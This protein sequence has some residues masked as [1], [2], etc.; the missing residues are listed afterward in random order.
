[1]VN[2]SINKLPEDLVYCILLRFPVKS[3]MRFKCISQVWYHFIQSTTFINLHLNRTTSVE[4]EFILFKYSIKE[5]AEEFKNVLSFLSGHDD[6]ALNPLFPD[7]DVSYMASNCSCTF[8]PLIGPCNG[9]IALTD[10]ITTI[11]INPATRNFRLL[12]PS[13]FGCPYGYHRSVEALGFVFDSIAN[14]YKIVRLSEVF[15]DPLND[16]PGPKESKVDIYDLSIDSWRELDCEQLPLIDR[17]PCAETFYKEAVH[18]FGTIYLT[19]VILC[20]DVSTEVFRNMKMPRTFILDNAQFPGLVIL[21]ESL[22]LI[23]YPNPSA[24]DHMQKVTHIWV[25]KEYGV[26]ESWILKDIIRLPPIEYPLDIWKNNLLLFQS[27][28]GLLISYNL[29]SDE[30][31]ELKLN[32]V[33]GSMSVKV[34]KESLT[35]IPRGLKL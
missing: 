4:D 11:L 7:V 2:G 24:I 31:K 6:D 22:T 15:W 1:M 20:F 34:Y 8:F 25:M 26:S 16:Y 14:D 19:M 21:S 23:C 17:V 5:D 13:P 3:L 12:P 29:N 18:W 33:P 35:S 28:S 32:G 9:L 27:K 30:V 10:S